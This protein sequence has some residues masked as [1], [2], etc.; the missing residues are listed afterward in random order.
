MKAVLRVT[1]IICIALAGCEKEN[2]DLL[3]GNWKFVKD[4]SPMRGD[5]TIP[6][7]NQRMEEYTK[8]DIRIRYD[9]EGT[10]TSRCNYS[11]TNSTVTISG[12]ELNG[13]TWSMDYDYWFEH[14]T[15]VINNDGGFEFINDYFVR[16]D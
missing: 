15:L 5:Y 6:L 8:D 4:Y 2:I 1:L 9:F 11:A 16:I 10:E 3:V 14:D 7:E 13:D 12:E